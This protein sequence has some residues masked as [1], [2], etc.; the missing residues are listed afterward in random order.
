[1]ASLFIMNSNETLYTAAFYSQRFMNTTRVS[2][3]LKGLIESHQEVG[4]KL[5]SFR[6]LL[7]LLYDRDS[8][9]RKSQGFTAL[10]SS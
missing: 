5:I 6:I 1:M 3:V 10:S 7:R 4:N 9:S 2:A 8:C